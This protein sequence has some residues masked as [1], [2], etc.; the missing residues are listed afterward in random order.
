MPLSWNEIKSRATQFSK[1][2][3]DTRREEAEAQ[4]FLIE[5]LNIFGITRKRVATFEH[6]IKKAD[7]HAGYID[8]LWKGMLLVE[9]KSRGEDMEKAYGQAKEYCHGL[10]EHELPKLILMGSPHER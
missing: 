10:K 9:M 1:E 5:F 6:K 7:A 3:K 4:P 2:W 8:L